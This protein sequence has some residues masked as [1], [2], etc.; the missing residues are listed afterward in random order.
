M[1]EKHLMHLVCLSY[2]NASKTL[3]R[4]EAT[5][6]PKNDVQRIFSLTSI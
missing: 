4:L 3:L 2:S 1:H 6:R 5:Q